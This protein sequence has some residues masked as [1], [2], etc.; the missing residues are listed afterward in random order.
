[1]SLVDR[2][3]GANILVLDIERRPGLAQV[4][5]QKTDFI[6]IYKWERMPSLLCF[7][8]KRYG[9]RKVEFVSAWDDGPEAMA[10]RS[11]ELYDAADIVVTYNGVNFDNKHLRSEWLLAG[12]APPA[13][14]K[15]VDVYRVNRGLFGFESKS[16]D[17]LC[18]RLGLDTKAG[19]YDAVLAEKC[20]EGD[21]AA[22]RKMRRYNVGDVKI[23]EQAYDALRPWMHQHP[24]MG[25]LPTNDTKS[26][27]ACGS[28]D[29]KAN[30]TYRAVAIDYVLFR[31]GNCGANVRGGSHSRAAA[32]R[33][34]R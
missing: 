33:G 11:W 20:L 21:P 32:T 22:Q 6:P 4:W 24:F 34:V 7:A 2:A 12:L 15:D 26:C 1:M 9:A 17:H 30:G 8:A 25:V 31:C 27:N 18:H 23:T 29:L 5:Q 19:H 14:W 3:K 16:L 13:P 28:T 10:R